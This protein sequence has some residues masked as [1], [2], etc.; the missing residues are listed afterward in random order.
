MKCQLNILTAFME[1]YGAVFL[2]LRVE[3]VVTAVSFRSRVSRLSFIRAALTCMEST[4][5][6]TDRIPLSLSSWVNRRERE[7]CHKQPYLA[8]Y[9]DT[10]TLLTL[11]RGV[12]LN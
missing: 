3:R 2:K 11:I 4:Q 6:L 1:S 7:V 5:L 12:V 10:A 8:I 9:R